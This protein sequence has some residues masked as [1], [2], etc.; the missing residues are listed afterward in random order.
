[1][2]SKLNQFQRL[3]VAIAY[4]FTIVLAYSIL[5]GPIAD[6]LNQKDQASVWFFSGILLVIMGKYVTEP[7]FSSP[8]DTLSNSISLTLF[9]TT[10]I[11]SN[12]LIG[13]RFLIIY[14]L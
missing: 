2:K 6:I 14:S 10:L 8:S 1:M 9:L 11:D 13:Y 4:V 12:K 3:L 5:G 7:Y